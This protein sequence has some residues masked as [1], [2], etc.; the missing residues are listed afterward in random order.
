MDP[1]Y[2]HVFFI[3]FITILFNLSLFMIHLLNQY[4]YNLIYIQLHIDL[5]L[6]KLYLCI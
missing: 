3:K 1:S 2:V 6:L 5:F 4:L